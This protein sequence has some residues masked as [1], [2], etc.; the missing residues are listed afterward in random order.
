M[1]LF[2][3]LKLKQL[4]RKL[5]KRIPEN[6]KQFFQ[7]VIKNGDVVLD[8]GAHLGAFSNYFKDCVGNN[9]RVI[10]FEPQE[11]PYRMFLNNKKL[12]KWDNVEVYNLALSDSGGNASLYVPAYK[13]RA[14]TESATLIAQQDRQTFSIETIEMTT[15]DYF[16]DENKIAPNFL[17]IDVEGNE[18]KVLKGGIETI[19]KYMPTIF[20]EIEARHCGKR[21]GYNTFEYLLDLG[22]HGWFFWGSRRVLVENF[23]FELHQKRKLKPYCNNFVF[24]NTKID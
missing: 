7:S 23:Y 4:V 19:K 11:E 9:G 16:C 2:K 12:L 17:K 14:D 15:L 24:E 21:L 13:H 6:E 3:R 1:N 8:I 20:V 22:Y 18:L 5:E 10:S